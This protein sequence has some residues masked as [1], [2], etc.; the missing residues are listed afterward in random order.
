MLKGKSQHMDLERLIK[1]QI[2][3]EKENESLKGK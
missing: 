2:P 1:Q 3:G